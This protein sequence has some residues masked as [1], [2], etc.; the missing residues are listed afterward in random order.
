MS[1]YYVYILANK[2]NGTIYIGA[3][4][5]LARRVSEHKGEK[6]KGFTQKYRVRQLVYHEEVSDVR[7]AF[8]REK[9]LK[10]WNRA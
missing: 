3:T 2:R 8:M 7:S 1:S 5:D 4:N 9:E 6:N 10:K